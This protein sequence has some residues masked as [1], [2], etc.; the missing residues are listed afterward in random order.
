MPAAETQQRRRRITRGADPDEGAPPLHR[1]AESGYLSTAAD[2][3]PPTEG[4]T[5][6]LLPPG[7]SNN[8]RWMM[9]KISKQSQD[10][11]ESTAATATVAPPGVDLENQ[12]AVHAAAV[13]LRSGGGEGEAGGSAA[14]PELNDALSGMLNKARRG[15][16]TKS[17]AVSDPASVPLVSGG[18]G[19]GGAPGGGEARTESDLR[20]EDLER[21]L[22]RPLRINDM[23]FSDLK[24]S[25]SAAEVTHAHQNSRSRVRNTKLIFMF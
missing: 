7:V 13:K 21:G 22:C 24:V 3:V 16:M 25:R 6:I 2:P 14:A 20:W 19:G 12:G 23:D 5:D 9:Y 1:P 11:A 8:R 15:L 4:A 10:D 17:A 18:G